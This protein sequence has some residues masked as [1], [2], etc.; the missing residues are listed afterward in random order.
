MR[1]KEPGRV[2]FAVLAAVLLALG[3]CAPGIA[4]RLAAHQPAAIQD[5]AFVMPDGTALP[6]QRWGPEA[7]PRATVIALHGFNDYSGAYRDL[8]PLLA[9]H[10]G[11]CL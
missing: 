3:G 10:A 5:D 9:R 7:S 11:L 4:P 1:R 8:G 2:L 6:Y